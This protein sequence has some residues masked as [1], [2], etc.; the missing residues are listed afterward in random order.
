MNATESANYSEY[1]LKTRHKLNMLI[2]MHTR[3]SGQPLSP[4]GVG[5]D[6]G[7][8]AAPTDTEEA[9]L[10]HAVAAYCFV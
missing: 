6:Q 4:V 1:G 7:H 10:L 2:S 5:L 8:E 3:R 9:Q